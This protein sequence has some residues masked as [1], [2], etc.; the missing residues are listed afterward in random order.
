[1]TMKTR[2]S[3]DS[4]WCVDMFQAKE[5]LF[6]HT[7]RCEKV[8]NTIAH[9]D[10]QVGDH[11]VWPS[12]AYVTT[13]WAMTMKKRCSFDSAWCVDMFQAEEHLFKHIWRCEKV[14][15][16]IAHVNIQVGDHVLWPSRAYVE[17]TWAM[18]MKKR[19]S[20]DS[21]WCVDMFQAKEHLFKDICH[22][23]V[24]S[25]AILKTNGVY[26]C[27]DLVE[28]VENAIKTS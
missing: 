20:F 15:D 3:F 4:L 12:R 19:Y 18:T 22:W 17:T 8:S 9:V 16:T 11:I 6:K 28:N 25:Y 24:P 7:W 14:S 21:L 27:Y 26:Q 10:I 5:H 2:Y 23:G 13:T 1:M